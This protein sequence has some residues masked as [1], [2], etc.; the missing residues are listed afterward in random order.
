[1]MDVAN[2]SDLQFVILRTVQLVK[3]RTDE[4]L[5]LF[6]HDSSSTVR[7]EK[8]GSS[9][10]KLVNDYDDHH[11][12]DND[13][14]DDLRKEQRLH[15][16]GL[17]VG[18]IGNY[19][20]FVC[21]ISELIMLG[22]V[23]WFSV[24]D[25]T[26]LVLLGGLIRCRYYTAVRYIVLGSTLA[27]NLGVI[28]LA[29]TMKQ[30]QQQQPSALTRTPPGVV[31]VDADA[32]VGTT[33]ASS[34]TAASSTAT[35]MK[36]QRPAHAQQEEEA[37]SNKN[38]TI[39]S[40]TRP[41][42]IPPPPPPVPTA[43]AIDIK[44]DT[45]S[46][47]NLSSSSSSSLRSIWKLYSLIALFRGFVKYY[48]PRLRYLFNNKIAMHSMAISLGTFL[49]YNLVA[50]PLTLE[51]STMYTTH[52]AAASSADAHQHHHQQYHAGPELTT[53]R[54]SFCGG[55][56]TNLLLQALFLNVTYMFGTLLYKVLLVHCKPYQ[57]FSRLF[58]ILVLVLSFI[59]GLLL[60][61]S[62]P[63]PS[64]SSA[65]ALMTFL[66]VSIAQVAPYHLTSY[67]WYVF[68]SAV[69]EQY[70]GFA[71]ALYGIGTQV[72]FL[73]PGLFMVIPQLS[74]TFLLW[75]CIALLFGIGTYSYSFSLWYK[76]LLLASSSQHHHTSS[77][78]SSST[79]LN[80]PNEGGLAAS[81]L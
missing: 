16:E 32:E 69:D 53:T 40:Q 80:K 65:S 8:H 62:A 59:L 45:L 47:A 15:I 35:T 49:F 20:D 60:S 1:M 23:W 54:D 67:T 66:L 58:P 73:A 51:E 5:S 25:R 30:P 71:Q 3:Q 10:S 50:Y 22:L 12:D 43:I 7:E 56:L 52:H 31:A 36:R 18:T 75:C 64:S 17:I 57:F 81:F 68:T 39:V 6:E 33:T 29:A 26:E 61:S 27:I 13:G 77:G 2:Q 44:N 34:I 42:P 11:H 76:H 37:D 72:I 4:L 21:H 28:Y 63:S 19:G 46:E 24:V 9:P 48:T 74:T 78:S 41:A 70:Y 79:S 14:D 55:L 38:N